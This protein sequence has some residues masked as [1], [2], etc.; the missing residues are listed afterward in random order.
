MT[1]R[2]V[3]PVVRLAGDIVEQFRHRPP[4]E[5]AHAAA[6]HI[7]LFWDP[8]MRAA[9][10]AASNRTGEVDPDI[11]RVVALLAA[12]AATAAEPEGTRPPGAADARPAQ[13][14]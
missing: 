3:E 4:D 9:L 14:M 1:D 8:R 13:R 11:R 6:D 10:Q 2:P 7:R 12:P 5:A